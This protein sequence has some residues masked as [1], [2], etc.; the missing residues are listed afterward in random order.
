MR[1]SIQQV[2]Q[3]IIQKD[4]G[5]AHT[6]AMLFV[7]RERKATNPLEDKDPEL[8]CLLNKFQDVLVDGL[9]PGLPPKQQ[10]NHQIE[11]IPGNYKPPNRLVFRMSPLELQEAKTQIDDLLAR[12][13][14]R[15]SKSRYGAPILFARKNDGKLRMYVD[16][17][18]L[19]NVTQKNS[20][21]IPRIDELLEGLTGAAYFSKIDL[22]AEYHQV[23]IKDK[24]MEKIAFNSRY[25]H[26]EWLVMSF[27]MTNAPGTF[28]SLMNEVFGDLL[29]HGVLVYLDDVLV[30]SRTKEE[31]LAKLRQVLQRLKDHQLYA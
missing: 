22:V 8:Q 3:R 1:P 2:T 13:Y 14:I 10:S 21:P 30:Y 6:E 28:Q 29:D 15:P 18:G 7:I 27:G 25:G 31:H 5:K 16:Y 23:Q 11:L 17:R 24:D 9:P 19:N 12:G 20:F 4:L 26:Y